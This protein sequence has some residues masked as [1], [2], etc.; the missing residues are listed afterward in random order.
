MDAPLK[1]SVENIL[2]EKLNAILLRLSKL[3]EQVHELWKQ[4]WKRESMNT[5]K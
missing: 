1:L 3:E 4:H 5:A 2:E